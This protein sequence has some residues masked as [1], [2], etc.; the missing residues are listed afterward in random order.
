MSD[1]DDFLVRWIENKKNKN[2]HCL[3]FSKIDIDRAIY[4]LLIID[5]SKNDKI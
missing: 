2:I 3:V 4:R 5:F 1:F